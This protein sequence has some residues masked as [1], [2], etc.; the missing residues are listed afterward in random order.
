[1]Y[2][3]VSR[4]KE[5]RK[6]RS[7]GLHITKDLLLTADV[8]NT[9]NGGMSKP[10]IRM[11][12]EKDGYILH[13]RLPGVAPAR[14]QVEIKNNQLFL[15]HHISLRKDDLYDGIHFIPFHIGFVVIPFDVEITQIKAVYEK[16]ELKV[17]MPFNEFSNG[18]HKRIHIDKS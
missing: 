7:G 2:F 8:M 18:Y 4:L 15:F 13:A 17:I 10:D 3:A 5:Q 11:S 16:G 12:R 6:M 1:M 9:L 14:M